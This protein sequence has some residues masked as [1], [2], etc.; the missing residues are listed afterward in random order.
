M[1]IQANWNKIAIFA[2]GMLWGAAI[3]FFAGVLYMRNSLIQERVSHLPFDEVVTKIQKTSERFPAWTV[4]SAGC[5]LPASGDGTRMHTFRLCHRTYAGDLIMQEAD[6]KVSCTLPCTF[7]VYE[8]KDGKTYLA[9]MNVSLLGRLL[10]GAP[11]QVFP[12][13]VNPEQEAILREAG[14]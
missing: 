1:K 14:F 9:R 7:S 12:K 2:I 4:Q 13:R 5:T 3:V 6:R 11:A 8:K 10:G